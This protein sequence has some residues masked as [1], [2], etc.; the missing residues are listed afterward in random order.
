MNAAQ[1][2]AYNRAYYA[3]NKEQLK[4]RRNKTLT[5]DWHLKRKYGITSADRAEMLEAQGFAC[6]ICRDPE[7]GG[8]GTWHV[9]HCHTSGRVRGL[10]CYRCNQGLG[11]F[12][13][14]TSHLEN[15]IAYLKA[16][17]AR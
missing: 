8:R 4:A 16:N 1:K 10:L 15:A 9:D 11:Y 13:D 7:P 17:D 3:A 14:N 5:D 12:R 6:A 2:R